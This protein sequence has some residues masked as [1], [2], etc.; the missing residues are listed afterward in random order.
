MAA[1]T[2]LSVSSRRVPPGGSVTVNGAGFC[3]DCSV[4]IGGKTIIPLDYSDTELVFMAPADIG[5]YTFTINCGGESSAVLKLFVVDLTEI[6]IYIPQEKNKETFRDMLLGL[7]PRGFG[8]FKGILGN[9]AKLFS[10]FA[11]VFLYIYELFLSLFREGSAS[12]TSS[13]DLWEQEL[14]LPRN[15]LTFTS[16]ADRRSEIYRVE[17]RKGGATIPYLESIATLF[18]VESKVYE[19]WKDPDSFPAWVAALGTDALMYWSVMLTVP[20]SEMTVFNCNSECDDYL[21]YWWNEPLESALLAIKPSHTMMIFIYNLV[22]N[23]YNVV[24]SSDGSVVAGDSGEVYI[25]G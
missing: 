8:W 21:R 12:H 16:A 10:G 14:G 19:Y 25:Y 11:V 4:S 17:C 22:N 7:M 9:W 6:P 24:A 13:F 18:G 5:D 2:V 23:V 20:A 15:D 1:P 3:P